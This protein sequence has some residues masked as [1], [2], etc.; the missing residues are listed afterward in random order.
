MRQEIRKNNN[1]LPSFTF[2]PLRPLARAYVRMCVMGVK[3][4]RSPRVAIRSPRLA[5]VGDI[6]RPGRNDPNSLLDATHGHTVAH[7]P[8]ATLADRKTSGEVVHGSFPAE[9]LR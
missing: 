8:S 5:H 3:E 9:I 1:S 6:P 7:G 2:P 4:E